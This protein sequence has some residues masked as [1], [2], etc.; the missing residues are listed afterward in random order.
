MYDF[1]DALDVDI[2]NENGEEMLDPEQ[3]AIIHK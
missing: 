2:G 3:K 1:E